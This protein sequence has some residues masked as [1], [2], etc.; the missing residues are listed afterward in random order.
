[1]LR[2]QVIQKMLQLFEFTFFVSQNR[3]WLL[4]AEKFIQKAL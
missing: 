3:V 4:S 1:M 2:N